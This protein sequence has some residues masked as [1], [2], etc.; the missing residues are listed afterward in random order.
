M[1]H[2]LDINE[3]WP[4]VNNDMMQFVSCNKFVF[5]TPTKRIRKLKQE[6]YLCEQR[7]TPNV[8]ETRDT[9]SFLYEIEM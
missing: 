6:K 7:K 9:N 4:K 8:L 2:N 1:F 3:F 5:F